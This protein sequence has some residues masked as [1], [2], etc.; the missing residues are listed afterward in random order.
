MDLSIDERNLLADFRC[1]NKVGKTEL[2]DYASFLIKKYQDFEG[3]DDSPSGN[4]CKLDKQGEEKTD[5]T[6]EPFFTE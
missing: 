5:A 3:N 4:L 2:L 6:K 1:L